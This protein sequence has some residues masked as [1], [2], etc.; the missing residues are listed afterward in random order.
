MLDLSILIPA[1][2]EATTIE[3]AVRLTLKTVERLG[4]TA[5]VIVVDDGSTDETAAIVRSLSTELPAV[6]LVQHVE[7]QGKGAAIASGARVAQGAAILFLDADLATPPDCL[8]TAWKALQDA[9]VVIGSRRHPKTVILDPQPWSRLLAGR[10]FLL[11]TKL[12]VGLP[13]SDTQCGFKL[14]GERARSLLPEIRAK[15]WAF[16]VEVLKRAHERGLRV[17]EIPVIWQHGRVSRVRWRQGFG[18]VRELWEM[19]RR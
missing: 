5:E 16:D 11:I 3:R 9:D 8:E 1:Y 13:Y 17:V 12:L 6:R 7:N 4:I 10:A 15:G 2:R 19:R 18:I 14:F